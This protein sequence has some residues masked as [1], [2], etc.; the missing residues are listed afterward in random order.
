MCLLTVTWAGTV[1]S[2]IATGSEAPVL[3]YA[4]LDIFA[5][6]W[7][8]F[9]Q[10]RNWQWMPAGLFASMLLTHFVFWSGTSGG[11]ILFEARPYQDI[12]AVL[13]YAQVAC[14]GWASH[15]RAR[16]RAMGPSRLGRWGLSADW[17][18]VRRMGH[19]RHAGAG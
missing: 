1:I 7:L 5:I 11:M 3:F 9:H 2:N 19:K 8:L 4:M 15:E 18:P 12:L 17:V 16:Q 13:G 10:R 14:V 6:V